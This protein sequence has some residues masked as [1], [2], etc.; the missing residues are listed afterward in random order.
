MGA[1]L[2]GKKKK[3]LSHSLKLCSYYI[4]LSFRELS[5]IALH[6]L[7]GTFSLV[8]CSIY[9]SLC[10]CYNSEILNCAYRI[11]LAENKHI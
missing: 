5:I 4:R 10:P 8:S 9:Q 7:L 2:L 11:K 3:R 6:Y 1:F